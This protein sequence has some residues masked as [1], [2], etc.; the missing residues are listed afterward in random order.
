[1]PA[2]GKKR[3][4]PFRV[5]MILYKASHATCKAN[6]RA[7]RPFGTMVKSRVDELHRRPCRFRPILYTHHP[8]LL[9]ISGFPSSP[10]PQ[11]TLVSHH[12]ITPST[13][14][15]N[16]PIPTLLFLSSTFLVSFFLDTP[17]TFFFFALR[18]L[19]TAYINSRSLVH[20][21]ILLVQHQQ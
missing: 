21:L 18:F 2:H 19:P 15:P 1:M 14:S 20:T 12:Y 8:R 13:L 5:K 17:L 7:K 6:I 11:A 3:E 16:S 4:P 10:I 9:F